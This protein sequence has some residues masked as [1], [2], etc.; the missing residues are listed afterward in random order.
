MDIAVVTR[1]ERG[2]QHGD[3]WRGK[4]LD[5]MIIVVDGG[6]TD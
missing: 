4:T 5:L 3:R 6:S 2:S 1:V